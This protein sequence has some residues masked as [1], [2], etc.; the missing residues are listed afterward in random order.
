MRALCIYSCL[1]KIC[2]ECIFYLKFCNFQYRVLHFRLDT[3]VFSSSY[4]LYIYIYN[5]PMN[6]NEYWL[7]VWL[8]QCY[9][10]RE[11]MHLYKRRVVWVGSH[12]A[13]HTAT[14][15]RN[16]QL[17]SNRFN[18]YVACQHRT[19]AL[20]LLWTGWTNTLNRNKCALLVVATGRVVSS[21]LAGWLT[22]CWVCV[23]VISAHMSWRTMDNITQSFGKRGQERK[24]RSTREEMEENCV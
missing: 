10:W 6:T 23:E 9:K 15:R 14:W 17:R 5:I 12:G 1:E 18:N 16:L 13:C 22:D 19:W 3:M 21:G 24:K 4:V 20:N 8:K 11:K 7:L 2:M